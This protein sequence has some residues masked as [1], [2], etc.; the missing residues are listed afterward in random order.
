MESTYSG[1]CDVYRNSALNGLPSRS[2][3]Q[4]A[5]AVP[6]FVILVE[7]VLVHSALGVP[8]GERSG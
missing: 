7:I 4:P 1:S 3:P 2:E 5:E 8:A 6:I